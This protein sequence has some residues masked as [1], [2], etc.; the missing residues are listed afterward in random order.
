[1][2]VVAGTARSCCKCSP[3]CSAACHTAPATPC[4]VAC[5]RDRWPAMP[6]FVA[7]RRDRWLAKYS[8]V[9]RRDHWLGK[10]FAASH[11]DR[12]CSHTLGCHTLGFHT[13]DLLHTLAPSA[14]RNYTTACTP[15]SLHTAWAYPR[16]STISS[17]TSQSS[18]KI[19]LQKSTRKH[20]PSASQ[21]TQTYKKKNSGDSARY[22]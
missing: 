12:C 2:V 9:C 22:P 6:C 10:H 3:G 20:K 18:Q 14:Q 5:R 17:S 8:A 4:S 1:M 19:H 11:M 16:K 21:F 13:L 15:T 7:C